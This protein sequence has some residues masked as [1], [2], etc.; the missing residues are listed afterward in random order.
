MSKTLYCEYAFLEDFSKSCP[1]HPDN[2]LEKDP[3]QSWRDAFQFI[4]RSD[5]VI[6]KL[7]ISDYLKIQQS[8]RLLWLLIKGSK[9]G[10]FSVVQEILNNNIDYKR[11]NSLYLSGLNEKERILLSQTFGVLVL[12][13][14]ELLDFDKIFNDLIIPIPEGEKYS[15]WEDIDFPPYARC[16]NSLI[17]QDNYVL[18]DEVKKK[19]LI[20]ILDTLLPEKTKITFSISIFTMIEKNENAKYEDLV[21]KIR[22]IRQ[23]L[24]F[25][26]TL[27][28]VYKDE[29][30]ARRI[31]TNNS[32]ICSEIGLDVFNKRN[33]ARKETFVICVP[34]FSPIGFSLV[35]N[36][37]NGIKRV[38]RRGLRFEFNYWGDEVRE[39]RLISYYL[40]AADDV[41]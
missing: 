30:H 19:N 2:P 20:T 36:L 28:K 21:N 10:N 15:S 11:A 5:R 9:S 32:L 33:E 12:G 7:S 40:D 1:K 25:K 17:V 4:C 34:T 8:N 41:E 13:K 14:K 16:S 38:E 29:F 26:V 24:D 23:S 27:Y 3:V 18:N 31:L 37:I 39:N 35:K 22:E 6:G